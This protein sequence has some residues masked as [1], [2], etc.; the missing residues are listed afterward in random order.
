L[1][2]SANNLALH[3]QLALLLAEQK[4]S[5]EAIENI[6]ICLKSDPNS[7]RLLEFLDAVKKTKQ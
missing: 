3:Y 6:R 1:T 4:R 5:D 7:A 2:F